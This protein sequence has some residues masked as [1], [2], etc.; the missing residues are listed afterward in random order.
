LLFYHHGLRRFVVTE[1]KTGAFK[2][3]Y[4]SKMNFY[5]NV[6]DARLR[7][8]DDRESV[9]IILCAQRNEATAK[10]A[11]HRVYAPIAVSTWQGGAPA[12]ELPPV[13]VSEDM[14]ED[15]AELAQ[16][17]EVRARLIDRV[18]RRTPEIIE[19]LRRGRLRRVGRISTVRPVGLS[20]RQ[21]L[22]VTER[23]RATAP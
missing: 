15:L 23:R 13:E 20:C 14:P 21:A 2:P 8:G 5:L 4:V 10:F 6:L 16:L 11:L 3:E 17:E 12:A 7:A 19:G 18:V 9:G 22:I 1:L